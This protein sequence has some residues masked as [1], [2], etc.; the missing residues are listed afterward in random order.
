VKFPRPM[1]F[2][3]F[4]GPSVASGARRLSALFLGLSLGLTG[5]SG[6][7]AADPTVEMV[8]KISRSVQT[9]NFEGTYVHQQNGALY[10]ARVYHG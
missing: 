8:Q 7:A 3:R 5:L 1:F 6:L 9:L 10:T 2:L 4:E